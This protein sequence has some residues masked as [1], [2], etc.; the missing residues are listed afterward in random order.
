VE[1][2]GTLIRLPLSP[3]RSISIDSKDNP[4][5]DIVSDCHIKIVRRLGNDTVTKLILI[6]RSVG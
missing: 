3:K 6:N 2:S 1:V 5:I 4:V